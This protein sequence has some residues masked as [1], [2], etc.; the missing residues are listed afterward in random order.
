MIEFKYWDLVFDRQTKLTG[1]VVN[2]IHR[3]RV[4]VQFDTNSGSFSAWIPVNQLQFIAHKPIPP[5]CREIRRFGGGGCL[6]VML[7]PAAVLLVILL[8]ALPAHAAGF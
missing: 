7:L 2:I 5:K 3:R 1:T 4:C 6:V 8:L